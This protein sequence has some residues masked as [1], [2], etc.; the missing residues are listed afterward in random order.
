LKGTVS[1]DFRPSVFLPINPPWATGYNRKIF[2]NLVS[3]SQRY[4]Q[5]CVDSALW[6]IALSRP[7]NFDWYF[8]LSCITVDEIFC[9][10]SLLCG[11]AQSRYSVLCGIGVSSLR[12]AR[13][14]FDSARGHFPEFSAII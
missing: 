4:L 6:R 2:S 7:E 3:I 12:I 5:R 9:T 1:R 11:T 14:G 8:T 13:C 10:S